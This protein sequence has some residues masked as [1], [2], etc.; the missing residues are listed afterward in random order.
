MGMCGRSL[1]GWGFGTLVF[2]FFFD[3]PICLIWLLSILFM[4]GVL[5]SGAERSAVIRRFLFLFLFFPFGSVLGE[6]PIIVLASP[7]RFHHHHH[8]HRRHYSCIPPCLSLSILSPL[9]FTGYCYCFRR[10]DLGGE[11]RPPVFFLVVLLRFAVFD[12]MELL[13][14]SIS[15]HI[16]IISEIERVRDR[17]SG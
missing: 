11:R 12:S 6:L 15:Y 9:S 5:W 8:Y 17:V 13:E 16:H 2:F 10:E 3:R 7:R 1:L 14:G 4:G